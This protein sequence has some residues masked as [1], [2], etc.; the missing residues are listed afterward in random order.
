MSSGFDGLIKIWKDL[1]KDDNPRAIKAAEKVYAI[2][3]K[4]G[5]GCMYF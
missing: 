4:V 5:S 2:A 3:A 1:E